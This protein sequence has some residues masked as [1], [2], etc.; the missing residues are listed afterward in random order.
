MAFFVN[1]IKNTNKEKKMAKICPKCKA[2]C[3]NATAVFCEYCGG[4]LNDADFQNKDI[5]GEY[6]KKIKVLVDGFEVDRKKYHSPIPE[7]NEVYEKANKLHSFLLAYKESFDSENKQIDN[8]IKKTANY[9]KQDSNFEVAFVGTV[10]AGKST[11]INAM[12]KHEYASSSVTPETSVLTKFKY[13]GVNS[14]KIT[15]YSKDEWD[16]LWQSANKN[17]Q[18][19]AAFLNEF[20]ELGAES[21]ISKYVGK[22]PINED[23]SKEN[24]KKYTGST[25]A[26]HY[27]VKE[28]E[29]SFSGFPFKNL[30]F[31]DTPGLDDAV[32]F[33]SNVTREYI[34]RAN[35]VLMC[36]KVDPIH[37]SELT[38]IYQAF[39]NTGGRPE[40]VFL[41]GT[42]LDIRNEPL[43]AW[44]ELKNDWKKNI[45][46]KEE[47]DT[48]KFTRKQGETNIIG[49]AAYV[50]LLCDMKKRGEELSRPQIKVLEKICYELFD[51]HAI[52]EKFDEIYK[53]ANV[54]GVYK[55][56]EKFTATA[57]QEIITD[58]KLKFQGLFDEVKKYFLDLN[59]DAKD[60][61]QKGQGSVDEII[62]KIK[63]EEK[64]LGELEQ[65]R[66]ELKAKIDEFQGQVNN[67]VKEINDAIDGVINSIKE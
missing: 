49:V 48:T 29:V 60:T 18:K 37:N 15:F 12:L 33:R 22:E 56:I 62:S 46:S 17:K 55:S 8:F 67:A 39:D 47:V 16:E 26:V 35:V 65:T 44:E 61:Y 14:L 30:V 24:L 42:Q 58:A 19:S 53:F 21:Q 64:A 27:F 3:K 54:D 38:T 51:T 34:S 11:L 25:D 66:Q 1:N 36:I 40:K 23:L 13:G 5:L 2:S 7:L 50:S 9:L 59:K 10:K 6:S 63:E 20:A 52:D 45:V 31:V 28:A 32:D 43:K 4:V 57:K 41:I